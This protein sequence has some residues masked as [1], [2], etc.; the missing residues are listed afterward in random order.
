MADGDETIRWKS[1]V[2]A[3]TPAGADWFGKCK[4][5]QLCLGAVDGTTDLTEFVALARSLVGR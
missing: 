5:V 4:G 1:M 3:F 2:E